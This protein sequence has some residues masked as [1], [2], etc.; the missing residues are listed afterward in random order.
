MNS[1][2]LNI[3]YEAG[4]NPL[5]GHWVF[6]EKELVTVQAESLDKARRLAPIYS[7]VSGQGRWMRIFYNGVE[8]FANA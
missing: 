3:V 2:T 4:E 1:Y 5:T 7:K 6:E 8:L